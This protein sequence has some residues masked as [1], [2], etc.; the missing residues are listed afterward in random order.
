MKRTLLLSFI[1]LL[2]L[3]ACGGDEE[4]VIGDPVNPAAAVMVEPTAA[5]PTPL[6]PAIITN[7]GETVAAEPV[8]SAA[9]EAAAPSQPLP[10]WPVGQFGYGAQSHALVGDPAYTMDVLKGQLGVDW[11]KVQLEWALVE[12]NRGEFFW[13][14]DTIVAEAQAKGLYLMFSFVGVPAWARADGVTNAPP[15]DFNEYNNFLRALMAQYPG[16]IHAIEIWNEQNLD[17]EWL[18]PAGLSAAEYTRLLQGAYTTIKEVDPSIIVISGALAPTGGATAADGTPAAIDDF[19]FLDQMLAAGF[20][21]YTDCVGAHHN[22]YNLPPDVTAEA[23]PSH[24]ES[25]T[26]VFRG[27][28]DNP[29]HSWSFKTTLDTYADK[30]QAVDPAKKLCVTEFGWASTEGYDESPEGFAFAGDNTLEEQGAY[31][32]QA[33]TQMRESGDVWIAYLFN[34]D[35]G[36]KGYGPTDDTVPYSIVD[37]QGIPRPA[38]SAISQME[39]TR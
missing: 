32:V 30:I 37:T 36:N 16:Q 25:E 9:E 15:D 3:A 8:E 24:P 12:P 10:A 14:Y 1:L 21:Q 6:P 17:R 18:T 22:G 31:I 19:V 26:A 7:D 4:E 20:L 39:K 33:Y 27:P 28:F 2:L 34:F 13:V 11:V 38:F 35:F 5:P 23:A 29:H